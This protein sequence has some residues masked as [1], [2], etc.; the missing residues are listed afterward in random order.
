VLNATTY[1]ITSTIDS[2]FDT[3]QILVYDP[4]DHLVYYTTSGG[5]LKSFDPTTTSGHAY[6]LSANPL[7]LAYDPVD[8]DLLVGEWISGCTSPGL[9]QVFDPSKGAFV[10]NLTAGGAVGGITFNSDDMTME[11]TASNAASCSGYPGYVEAFNASTFARVLKVSVTGAV[12]SGAVY[13]P[14]TNQLFA[15]SGGSITH[16][17]N[18]STARLLLNISGASQCGGILFDPTTGAV[19]VSG[20]NTFNVT[21]INATSDVLSG[22]LTLFN[23]SGGVTLLSNIQQMATDTSGLRLIVSCESSNFVYVFNLS[24]SREIAS[25][26]VGFQPSGSAFDPRDGIAVVSDSETSGIYLFNFSSGLPEG[27]L[28]YGQGS[29]PPSFTW[30]PLTDRFYAAPGGNLMV[31][32]PRNLTLSWGGFVGN[33][34]GPV[35]IDTRDKEVFVA[36][37]GWTYMYVANESNLS[38]A[39][40]VPLGADSS[41]V[42]YD[43]QNGRLYITNGA[44]VTVMN[45]GTQAIVQNIT[46]GGTLLGEAIDS[47]NSTLYILE[48]LSPSIG[49][50]VALDITNQT[51]LARTTVTTEPSDISLDTAHGLIFV[52]EASSN[53]LTVISTSSHKV[54]AS[55][56]VGNTPDEESVVTASGGLLVSNINS[57]SISFVTSSGEERYVLDFNERG[58][59]NGSTWF[60]TVSGLT[61]GSNGINN[62]WEVTNGTYRYSIHNVSSYVPSPASGSITVN[63]ANVTVNVRFG[64]L[65]YYVAQFDEK[66]LPFGSNWSVTV[67]GTSIHSS[68]GSLSRALLNGTYNYSVPTFGKFYPTSSNGSFQI[69]GGNVT[70]N[71]TFRERFS[72]VMGESGLPKGT[73]WSVTLGNLSA[74]SVNST[75]VFS[76]PNGTYSWS[77]KPIP[78]YTT[79]W[80]GGASVN[81]SDVAVNVTFS[82]ITYALTFVET[83]L[84]SGTT[85]AVTVGSTVR[86]SN[87]T[88]TG[89]V[90]PNGTYVWSITPVAGF[91]TTWSGSVKVSGNSPQ[92]N[93]SFATVT[94]QFT[95]SET[96]LAIGTNW[97]V[98]VGTNAMHSTSTTIAFSLPNGTYDW[99]IG[100]VPGYR[101]TW[102]G[103]VVVNG[104]NELLNAAFTVVTYDVTFNESGLPLGTDWWV[105]ITGGLSSLS[106]STSLR[107]NEPNGSYSYSVATNE[108][109][110]SSTGGQ[111]TIDNGSD[112]VIATFLRV[113]YMIT[114]FEAGLPSGDGWWVNVSGGQSAFSNGTTASLNETN[115]TYTFSVA[116]SANSYTAPGGRFT[117][118]GGTISKT[119]TFTKTESP[120]TYTL[121]FSETGLP[122]GTNWSVSLNGSTESSSGSI[123]FS[124]L[125]NGTY[126]FA[127]GTIELYSADPASGE[128]GVRGANA[129]STVTFFPSITTVPQPPPPETFLGLPLSEGYALL[130]VIFIMVLVAA[131]VVALRLRKKEPPADAPDSY[132]APP[133]ADEQPSAP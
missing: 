7:S 75:I 84:P 6:N 66:G 58:L 79:N 64:V 43:S 26:P 125:A 50:V 71:V 124:G 96:G 35:A 5:Y 15:C 4:Y 3:P 65:T 9:V 119:L 117:V 102:R 99:S 18:A 118:N 114:F 89:F 55:V 122:D 10:A 110:Y 81:G 87:T 19:Y 131:A 132:S 25:K 103:G 68:A 27:F 127:V 38:S 46:I 59:P 48:S 92:V 60:T 21:V 70:I 53:N 32:D 94:Y 133:D 82:R 107:F 40:R 73:N 121:T 24:S 72:I 88:S 63:G 97:T 130:G 123:V 45:A 91:E 112:S 83:G 116:T 13:D 108:K 115:G 16:V 56:L 93:I 77:I 42:V 111:I 49:K 57:G 67:N 95:V 11:V 120:R 104:T 126:S 22:S 129:T 20:V 51:V 30:D 34:G 113:V 78:G 101:T 76:E 54:V 29:A 74:S 85:W 100:P 2:P 47:A 17:F 31:I 12:D 128:I 37:T 14:I 23:L 90:E 106:T 62:Y 109:T 105:N 8:H 80:T 41:D 33:S 61:Q 44:Q 28:Y 39:T 86:T 52:T 69:A 1:N 36:D 98:V